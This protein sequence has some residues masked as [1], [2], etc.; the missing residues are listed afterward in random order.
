[1]FFDT[2]AHLFLS[3]YEEDRTEVIYRAIEAGVTRMMLPNVDGDTIDG[4]LALAD[5]FP[6]NCF[7]AIG[8]H[9]TSVD[10]KL[11]EA[12]DNVNEHLE[13][14]NFYAIGETGIDLYWDKTN[15]SGQIEAFRQQIK[16]AQ[17]YQLPLIIHCRDSFDEIIEV[18]LDMNNDEL[19]GI[20]HSFTGS[21]EQAEKVMGAGFMLGIG[22]ILTFKN[23]GLDQVINRIP[24][25]HIVLETDSPYLAPHPLRGK[26]NES[27]Y[28]VYTARKLAELHNRSLDEIAEITT[29]NALRLFKMTE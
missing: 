24:L 5:Q 4:M 3:Q 1:M 12:L 22:G 16:L 19:T 11:Q 26:R 6:D 13:T 29:V 25:E 15:L 8:L 14:G 27:S 9:P 2:H 7:P 18:V 28:L 17:Q 10:D 21:I 20:F 23:S